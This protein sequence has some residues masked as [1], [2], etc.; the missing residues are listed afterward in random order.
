M[1]L[2]RFTHAF[3][4]PL[5]AAVVLILC[6]TSQADELFQGD[7]G[8]PDQGQ[9]NSLIAPP[10]AEDEPLEPQLTPADAANLV[11][12]QTGGQ[13]MSV[14]TKQLQ[15]GTVYG[16]KILNSGRMRVVL[17]DGQTGELINP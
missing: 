14:S 17:V 12:Q 8:L 9:S 5:L 10:V 15:S 13:V 16:V 3:C 2:S 7:L 4:L 11:R 1:T 6:Q